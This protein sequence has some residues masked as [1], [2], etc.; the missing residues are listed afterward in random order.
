[1]PL[2]PG[3][4]EVLIGELQ[5][6]GA[7]LDQAC[8]LACL[9]TQSCEC[10]DFIEK[11]DERKNAFTPPWKGNLEILVGLQCL[12]ICPSFAEMLQSV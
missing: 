6:L 1:M 4:K 8:A 5:A 12:S 3:E 9:F 11:P 7:P 10:L 2:E